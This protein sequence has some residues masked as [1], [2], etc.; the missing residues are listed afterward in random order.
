[1]GCRRSREIVLRGLHQADEHILQRG[2]HAPDA[3]AAVGLQRGQHAQ[4]RGIILLAVGVGVIGMVDNFLRPILLSGRTTMNGL[5]VFIS[6]M[7]DAR[8]NFQ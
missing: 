5:L 6:L 7:G 4:Q 3:V 8:D 2:V 1:M